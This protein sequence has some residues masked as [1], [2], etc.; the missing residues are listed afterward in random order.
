M[1]NDGGKYLPWKPPNPVAVSPTEYEV[2]ASRRA[3]RSGVWFS[4][5]QENEQRLVD[6]EEL[7]R[8]IREAVET[9]EAIPDRPP[10]HLSLYRLI[11]ALALERSPL[12]G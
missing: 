8:R 12:D 11:D 1:T 9:W 7:Q 2:E 6:A 3:Q 10:D 4:C 5:A